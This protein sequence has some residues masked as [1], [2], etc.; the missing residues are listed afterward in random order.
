LN[1][2]AMT[3]ALASA[4]G[5]SLG[6]PVAS[7]RQ[8][9]GG[10]INDAFLLR[11]ADERRFFV[12]SHAR[13][14][15]GL[16]T[17]EARGLDWLREADALRIPRVV[18]AAE[19]TGDVPAHLVLELIERGSAADMFD[20]DLGAGLARL[21]RMGAPGFGHVED[22]FIGRLPQSNARAD[23]WAEF[24]AEQRVLP[25]VRAAVDGGRAPR[26]WIAV[27][28]ALTAKLA[29]RLGPAEP[30][31]RLHGDLWSGNVMADE[32]GAPVLIDPA[33]YGGH[34]EID[35]AMLQLFGSPRGEFFDAYSEIWPL[36]P[37][38]R[39]RVRLYQLYP[40]LVHVNL[41]GG[42]YVQSADAVLR[43]YA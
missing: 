43:A 36:S 4:L 23:S 5:A 28:D 29:T 32:R 9:S 20:R 7:A 8:T 15:I 12:K 26:A 2:G 27:A 35:L 42:S 10:D 30:A 31:A 13:A 19:A 14:P 11:L 16:F 41:F 39:E 3:P 17:T 34:R 18:R 40:L 21:H 24:Y 25:L 22:N 1:D 38:W 33:V 6:S 37:G